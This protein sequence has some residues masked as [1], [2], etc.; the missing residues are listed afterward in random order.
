[1]SVSDYVNAFK[2]D[3]F[4]RSDLSRVFALRR[5]GRIAI[6]LFA[7]D[8]DDVCPEKTVAMRRRYTGLTGDG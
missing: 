6:Q 1:M 4:S 2:A 7:K 8:D 5:G 3:R